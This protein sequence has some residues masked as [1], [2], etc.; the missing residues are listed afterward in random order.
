MLMQVLQGQLNLVLL[1]L[2]TLCWVAD[3]AGRPLAAGCLIGTATA[4]KLFPAFLF[5]YFV[6]RRCWKALLGGALALVALTCL[7]IGVLGLDAY[8][9]YVVEAI[10]RASEFRSSWNNASLVGFWTRLFDP[11]TVVERVEPLVRSPRAALFGVLTSCLLVAVAIVFV[12]LKAV[13]R[14]DRDRAFSLAVTGML[15]VSPI[16]WYHS[17][18]LLLL[19]IATTWERLP[20]RAL[21][22]SGF[23][24]MIVAF[25]V[26]PLPL[27]HIF[28]GRVGMVDGVAAT[29]LHSL[30]VLSYQFYALLSL[31]V[32]GVALPHHA[33]V[34]RSEAL[35]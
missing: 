3:R 11:V 13:T 22:T 17:L 30:T 19:P 5:I 2:V 35:A 7:T 14:R 25:W 29:P 31:F 32:L 9:D 1:F 10:P 28:I 26:V 33:S 34:D 4:I 27:Q 18:V 8:R 16:T 12:T 21:F 15:L 23:A 6:A 24:L 20:R